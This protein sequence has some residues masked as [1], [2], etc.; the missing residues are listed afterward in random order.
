M[1]EINMFMKPNIAYTRTTNSINDFTDCFFLQR[2]QTSL[3]VVCK[4]LDYRATNL[5]YSS[6]KNEIHYLT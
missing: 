4:V 3:E 6:Q 2:L 5:I 1:P